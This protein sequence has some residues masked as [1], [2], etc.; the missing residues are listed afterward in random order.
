MPTP[1]LADM[2]VTGIDPEINNGED[3]CPAVVTYVT[4]P[5]GTGGWTV[6]VRA[7]PNA[8][9][10]GI[11]KEDVTLFATEEDARNVGIA[12]CAYW[13]PEPEPVA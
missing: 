8:D 10:D 7:F 3:V 9:L 12:D 11:W 13:P 2:V 6:N 5:S 1:Q 4:G